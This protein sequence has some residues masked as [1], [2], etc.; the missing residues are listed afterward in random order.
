MLFGELGITAAKFA[1]EFVAGVLKR[2][3]TGDNKPPCAKG[4][5]ALW[6]TAV[7]DT[8]KE[9]GNKLGYDHT[10]DWLVDFIWWS[11][12]PERLGLVAES[13]WDESDEDD[14][15]KLPVFKCPH[16]LLVFSSDD[17]EEKKQMAERY[18]QTLTQHVQKEE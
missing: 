2:M 9:L 7:K 6:T 5:R 17:P 1:E 8:L 10:Y 18:L 15:Q 13:E 14:F 11:T 16:K 12:K 4:G 3:C